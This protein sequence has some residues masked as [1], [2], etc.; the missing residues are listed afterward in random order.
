MRLPEESPKT[1]VVT[2]KFE[3]KTVDD[4]SSSPTDR[5]NDPSIYAPQ[6]PFLIYDENKETIISRTAKDINDGELNP[7]E[8]NWMEVTLYERMFVNTKARVLGILNNKVLNSHAF[9]RKF[10]KKFKLGN[11]KSDL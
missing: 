6:V 3:D 9:A 8:V 2:P 11:K 10:Y 7:Y 4:S 5:L 1:E